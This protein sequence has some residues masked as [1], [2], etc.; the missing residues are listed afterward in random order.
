VVQSKVLITGANGFVGRALTQTL[1][2][3]GLSPRCVVRSDVGMTGE[4]DRFVLSL[5]DMNTDWTEALRDCGVVIHL[6][7]R[8]HMMNDYSTNPLAEFRSLN[9]DST[10]NL[11]RQAAVAGIR[12]FVF[13][14]SVK[15]NGE[16]TLAGIPF[17]ADDITNPSD[18]YGISKKEAEAGLFEIARQTGM[19]VVIVRPT[20]VYGNGVKANF[21][22]MMKLLKLRLPL[23][24]GAI[25]SNRRSFVGIDNLVDFLVT[26]IKHPAAANQIFMVSDGEDIS[27]ADLLKRLSMAI[28]YPAR[29]FNVSPKL[30]TLAAKL[31]GKKDVA[32]RLLGNLQVDITKNK[33]LLGWE[34]PVSVDEGF[35]RIVNN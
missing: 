13:V 24:L 14:S 22:A 6:A 16:S 35:R 7:A 26:S 1:I 28:G 33:E 2:H 11:A 25:F 18:P 12:R 5:I 21:A 8:V 4:V 9:V 31:L 32:Q 34:P 30:L 3:G 23:P 27:T 19:E 29:L 17:K 10:L 15:V 20:L